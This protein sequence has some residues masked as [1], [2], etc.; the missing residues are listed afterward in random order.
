MTRTFPALLAAAALAAVA[1]AGCSS[2]ASSPAGQAAPSP[3]GVTVTAPASA[4]A[5]P[6]PV[7]IVRAAGAKPDQATADSDVNGDLLATGSFPSGEMVTV[8]TA[9]SSAALESL[10][11]LANPA[12]QAVIGG[13]RFVVAVTGPF[14]LTPAQIAHAVG[15]RVLIPA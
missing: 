2:S 3:G 5:A 7:A 1:L 12:G 13:D 8:Y 15:G 4:V 6:D 11:L 10:P 9:T 14:T